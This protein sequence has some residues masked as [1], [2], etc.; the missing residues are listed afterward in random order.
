M[1]LVSSWKREISLPW[2]FITTINPCH[3]QGKFGAEIH[4]H[5]LCG[6]KTPKVII[7]FRLVG[8]GVSP[9]LGRSQCSPWRNA[10]YVHTSL[11]C[12]VTMFKETWVHNKK[13]LNT[14]EKLGAS[15]QRTKSVLQI[16][17]AIIILMQ[18][19]LV[20]VTLCEIS[21]DLYINVII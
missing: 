9:R 15:Q 1:N 21:Q 2:E 12:S 8:T 17:A 16:T 11:N 6:M 20:Y 4:T 14:W 5:S 10:S 13:L 3:S 19:T 18:L 7:S